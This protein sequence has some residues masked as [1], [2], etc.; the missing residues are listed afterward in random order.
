MSKKTIA[1]QNEDIIPLEDADFFRISE[2][3]KYLIDVTNNSGSESFYARSDLHK[4]KVRI[5]EIVEDL[6]Y[7]LNTARIPTKNGPEPDK[8]AIQTAIKSAFNF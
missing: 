2:H 7:I 5:E 6:E 4:I 8:K 3:R 1:E